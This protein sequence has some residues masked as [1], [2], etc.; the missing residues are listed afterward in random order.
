MI[1]Y[2]I[3]DLIEYSRIPIEYR[4]DRYNNKF[5]SIILDNFWVKENNHTMIKL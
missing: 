1:I 4:E 5:S 2:T 3:T